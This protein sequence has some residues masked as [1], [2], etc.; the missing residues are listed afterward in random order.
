MKHFVGINI[1]YI[2]DADGKFKSIVPSHGT[3]S[4]YIVTNR[5][6]L[7]VDKFLVSNRNKANKEIIIK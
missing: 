2:Y 3:L 6:F 4:V 5:K 1:F 7:L